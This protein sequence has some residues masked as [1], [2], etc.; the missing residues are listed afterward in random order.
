MDQIRLIAFIVFSMAVLLLW[1]FWQ[2]EHAPPPAQQTI[3]NKEASGKASTPPLPQNKAL[4]SQGRVL[5][6]TDLFTAEID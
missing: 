6:N 2:K 3:A 4:E 1:E 5:V